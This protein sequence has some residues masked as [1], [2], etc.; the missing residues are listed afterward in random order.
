MVGRGGNSLYLLLVLKASCH[1]LPLNSVFFEVEVAYASSPTRRGQ[2]VTETGILDRTYAY[3]L[4]SGIALNADIGGEVRG[5]GSIR[6]DGVWLY[7]FDIGKAIH[8]ELTTFGKSAS[9]VEIFNKKARQLRAGKR[10]IASFRWL[11]DVH[12]GTMAGTSPGVAEATASFVEG[13]QHS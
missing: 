5:W 9:W 12:L 13:A 6:A 11:R 4:G 7:Q 2:L 1:G 8:R 3:G 10:S